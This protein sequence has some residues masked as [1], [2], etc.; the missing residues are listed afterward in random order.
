[1]GISDYLKC[2]LRNLLAGQE[3]PVATGQG[4]MGWFKI[5]K[6]VCQ[7]CTLSPC[8][9]NLDAKYIMG[10]ARLDEA[11]TRIKIVWRNI[12]KLRDADDTILKAK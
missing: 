6:G 12:N 8:L 9:F 11:Q 3:A 5:E 1:M 4:T 7:G 10:N 2:I